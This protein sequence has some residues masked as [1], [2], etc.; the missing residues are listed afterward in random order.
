MNHLARPVLAACV[1]VLV[2]L[3]TACGQTVPQPDSSPT[4]PVTGDPV[5]LTFTRTGGFI[6]VDDKVVVQPDGVIV[7]QQRGSEPSSR[8]LGDD[9][10]AEL[11]NQIHDA[12]ISSVAGDYQAA[13]ADMFEY[14][15][16]VDGNTLTADEPEVPASAQPLIT[17]LSGYLSS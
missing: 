12:D 6:G 13:G 11:Q 1:A 9:E 2:G 16:M 7:V 3:L 8:A 10:F 14:S 5:G 15:I 4:G 17:T